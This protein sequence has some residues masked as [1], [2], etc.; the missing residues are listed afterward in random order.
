M[1]K[2]FSYKDKQEQ[3]SIG[4]VWRRASYN[5]TR[6]WEIYKQIKMDGQGPSF[7]FVQVLLEM[8]LLH[9]DVFDDLFTTLER[10]RPLQDLVVPSDTRP[11]VPVERPPKIIGIGRNY[12]KHAQELGNAVPEEPIFFAKA[13]SSIIAS[14][15]TIYLPHDAGR[16]D[17]EGELAVVIGKPG[18]AISESAA[19]EHIA[20]YTLLNDVTARELQA[21]DK[22][23]GLPWFRAKSFDTFCPIGPYLIPAE[24][25]PAVGD[26][27]LIVRVNGEVRQNGHTSDM[28]FAIPELIAYISR[29]MRLAA[30]DIIATGTPEGVGPLEDGDEVEVE[31][32]EFGVL[33]NRVK[34]R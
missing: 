34:Q 31:I 1:V 23:K 2:V 26:L 10:Y 22:G 32:A 24:S 33:H 29:H 19:Q 20:G 11:L 21:R 25:V 7:P 27:Q 12:G 3:P 5:F 30:G 28:L 18:T 9:N 14:G 4:V 15:D 17:H 6:A 13:T 8:D 16:V